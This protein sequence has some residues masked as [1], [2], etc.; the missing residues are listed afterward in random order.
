MNYLAKTPIYLK[1]LNVIE[2]ENVEVVTWLWQY[3]QGGKYVVS[4]E[5]SKEYSIW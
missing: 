3:E 4:R 1:A 5:K 2:K